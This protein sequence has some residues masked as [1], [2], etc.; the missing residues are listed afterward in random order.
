M[1]RFRNPIHVPTFG[2]LGSTPRRHPLLRLWAR[3]VLFLMVITAVAA[4]EQLLLYGERPGQVAELAAR[5]FDRDVSGDLASA[6]LRSREAFK[7]MVVLSGSGVVTAA[8][9]ALFLPL[10]KPA[11]P[12]LRD[13][14]AR[15]A[16]FDD[17]RTSRR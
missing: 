9:V 8:A 1:S 12:Q 13:A 3:A 17:E 10:A 11:K 6:E 7:A 4:G 2:P 5:Q 15:R 14:D 16:A